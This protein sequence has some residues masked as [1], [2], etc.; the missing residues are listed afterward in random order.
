MMDRV[1]KASLC[2]ETNLFF[3]RIV[4]LEVIVNRINNE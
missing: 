1:Q 2:L 3:H 4:E